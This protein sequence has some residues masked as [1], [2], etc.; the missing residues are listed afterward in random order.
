MK[1]LPLLATAA[2]MIASLGIA[3]CDINE[4]PAEKAGEKVDNAVDKAGEAIEDTGDKI[5]EK[6][7]Q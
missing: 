2:L 5:H 6:T 4:G 7:Q 3:G 1:A